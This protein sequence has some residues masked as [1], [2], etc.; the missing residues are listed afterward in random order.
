MSQNWSKNTLYDVT[1]P[2]SRLLLFSVFLSLIPF[3][4]KI[5]MSWKLL[6]PFWKQILD[7]KQ[8]CLGLKHYHCF[9]CFMRE[10]ERERESGSKEGWEFYNI[11]IIVSVLMQMVTYMFLSFRRGGRCFWMQLW[12]SHGYL[13]LLLLLQRVEIIFYFYAFG[14]LHLDGLS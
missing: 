4:L 13:V 10:R 7:T 14:G 9:H 8:N 1:Y 12:R 5:Q 2:F 6:K 11:I 3:S